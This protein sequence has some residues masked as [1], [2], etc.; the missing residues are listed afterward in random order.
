MTGE[1]IR[2][3]GKDS[4]RNCIKMFVGAWNARNRKRPIADPNGPS[5]A[6]VEIPR[7]GKTVKVWVK[8][9]KSGNLSLAKDGRMHGNFLAVLHAGAFHIMSASEVRRAQVIVQG[10]CATLNENALRGRDAWEKL[11]SAV[12]S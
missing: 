12:R 11:E 2:D 8:S 5:P 1:A 4:S 10:K 6:V 9:L 3:G 7:N